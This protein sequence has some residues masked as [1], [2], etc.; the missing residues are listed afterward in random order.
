M[1]FL[2]VTEIDGRGSAVV[3][4][5]TQQGTKMRA[6]RDDFSAFASTDGPGGRHA[7]ANASSAPQAQGQGEPLWIAR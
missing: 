3:T 5:V 4:P 2:R 7:P 6:S 1:G